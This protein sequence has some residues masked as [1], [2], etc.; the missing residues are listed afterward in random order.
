MSRKNGLKKVLERQRRSLASK[1]NAAARQLNSVNNNGA[2][3]Q[4]T[5]AVRTQQANLVGLCAEHGGVLQGSR[6]TV[7][8][9]FASRISAA[10]A[11]ASS[12]IRLCGNS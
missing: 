5:E 8:A 9:H 11:P 6:A 2:V 7:N 4:T 12:E 10:L 3:K 1:I